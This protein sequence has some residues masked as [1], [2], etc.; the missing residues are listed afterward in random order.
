M[1]YKGDIK[2]AFADLAGAIREHNET[3]RDVLREVKDMRR[4]IDR[5]ERETAEG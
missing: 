1:V 4:D 2:A 5:L 3:T